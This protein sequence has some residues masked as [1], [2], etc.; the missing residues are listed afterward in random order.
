MGLSKDFLA[1]SCAG[2]KLVCNC[3]VKLVRWVSFYKLMKD[4]HT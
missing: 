4:K 1:I 3:M 2:K